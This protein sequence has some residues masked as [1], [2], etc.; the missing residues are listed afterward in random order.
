MSVDPLLPL[1]FPTNTLLIDSG[2]LL[3]ATGEA[4]NVKCFTWSF[5]KPRLK[6]LTLRVSSNL[7]S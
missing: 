7:F 5:S 1:Y 6:N 3:A 2:P 4:F